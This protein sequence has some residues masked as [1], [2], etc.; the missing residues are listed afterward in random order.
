MWNDLKTVAHS[1]VHSNLEHSEGLK[2]LPK[3]VVG[4]GPGPQLPTVLYSVL[5][6]G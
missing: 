3:L 5:H 1:T 6:E 2:E 4:L